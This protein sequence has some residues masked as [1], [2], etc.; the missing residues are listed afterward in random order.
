[1]TQ[2][3]GDPEEIR[4]FAMN[5]KRFNDQV[6]QHASSLAAQ[7]GQLRQT[8]RDDRQRR[9]E[10]E[11]EQQMRALQHLLETTADHIPALMRKADQLDEYLGR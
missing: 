7:M 4:R 10:A 6:S 5:L 9:F 11:F 3:I 8:W 1:M 2:A